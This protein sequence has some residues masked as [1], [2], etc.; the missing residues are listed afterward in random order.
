MSLK[1][2]LET[3]HIDCIYYGLLVFFKFNFQAEFLKNFYLESHL[4]FG[5]SNWDID[6]P[7][8]ISQNRQKSPFATIFAIVAAATGNHVLFPSIVYRYL[9]TRFCPFLLGLARTYPVGIE[10]E[11]SK[12]SYSRGLKFAMKGL[13]YILNEWVILYALTW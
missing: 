1:K 11:K 10:N 7:Q 4:V 9:I 8:N 3:S 2:E 6:P 13:N 12:I 5:I